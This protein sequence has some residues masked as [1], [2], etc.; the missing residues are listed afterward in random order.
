MTT[1]RRVTV[2]VTV[3]LAALMASAAVGVTPSTGATATPVSLP[4]GLAARA[5][6]H[7]LAGQLTPQGFVPVTGGSTPDLS[8]TAQ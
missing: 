5:A 8:G 4:Q 2:V 1:L 6:A 3:A 7:W